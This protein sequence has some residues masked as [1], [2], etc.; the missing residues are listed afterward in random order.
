MRGLRAGGLDVDALLTDRYPNMEAFARI[1]ES[2]DGVISYHAAPIDARD[3]PPDL[4]GVRTIFNAF[5]HFRP[6]DARKV[7]R[8]AVDSGQAL[9][10]FEVPERRIPV[11]VMTL[12]APLMVLLTTPFIRP[13]RWRRLVF[14]Y[15]APLVPLTCLWDGVVSQLRAYTPRELRQLARDAGGTEYAW[16]AGKVDVGSIP[17]RLTYLLGRPTAGAR[18]S[19]TARGVR[20]RAARGRC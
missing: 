4:R 10:V 13:F 19:A 7:I 9:A 12:L 14:T 17:A 6:A 16:T 2:S 15:L 11:V 8:S 20:E 18:P 5:H 3:V 1:A